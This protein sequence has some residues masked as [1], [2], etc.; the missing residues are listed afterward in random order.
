MTPG[1]RAF[2][3]FVLPRQPELTQEVVDAIDCALLVA[4][5]FVATGLAMTPSSSAIG[6]YLAGVGTMLP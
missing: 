1:T 6:E 4:I 3:R 2:L 5:V